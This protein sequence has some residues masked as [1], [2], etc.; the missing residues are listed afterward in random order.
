MNVRERFQQVLNQV[1][2]AQAEHTVSLQELVLRSADLSEEDRASFAVQLEQLHN[3]NEEM[4]KVIEA[5]VIDCK[6]E[7]LDI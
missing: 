1:E 2:L 6:A 4:L 7:W 5:S 3:H